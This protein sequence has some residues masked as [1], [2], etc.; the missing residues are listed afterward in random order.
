MGSGK[1]KNRDARLKGTGKFI[2]PL[3]SEA[4]K[5]FVIG[6]SLLKSFCG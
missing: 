5:K 4:G 6:T 2:V 3:E 1:K